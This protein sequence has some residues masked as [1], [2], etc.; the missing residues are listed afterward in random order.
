MG[1]WVGVEYVECR[2]E[3]INLSRVERVEG[4]GRSYFE[5]RVEMG[6]AGYFGNSG[7]LSILARGWVYRFQAAQFV[8][9]LGWFRRDLRNMI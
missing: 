7:K 9:E 3:L 5:D 2:L 6:G 4:R 1:R 8:A